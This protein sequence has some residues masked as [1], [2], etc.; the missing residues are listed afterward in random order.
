M[1]NKLFFSTITLIGITPLLLS[2]IPANAKTAMTAA[3]HKNQQSMH[4]T[5][6]HASSKTT[7]HL[8]QAKN[9]SSAKIA[10]LHVGSRGQ[11]VKN[12]QAFLKNQGYFKGNVDGV[13]GKQTR[14]AVIAFQR[15]QK[16]PANGVVDSKTELAMK[17]IQ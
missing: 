12:L 14:S 17:K 6:Q 2:G 1:M 4:T 9:T 5:A 16:L 7:S 3:N 8:N 11:N 13:F 15:S 10:S